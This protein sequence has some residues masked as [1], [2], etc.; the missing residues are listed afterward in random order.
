MNAFMEWLEERRDLSLRLLNLC[1]DTDEFDEETLDTAI[2]QITEQIMPLENVQS[3]YGNDFQLYE[4][5][6]IIVEIY[7]GE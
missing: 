2:T 1:F 6:K 3:V 4:L 7:E 5:L